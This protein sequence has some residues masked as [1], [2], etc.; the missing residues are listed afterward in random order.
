MTFHLQ[1]STRPCFDYHCAVLRTL[2]VLAR[3]GVG[4]PLQL[5]ESKQLSEDEEKKLQAQTPEERMRM[6]MLSGGGGG[7]GSAPWMMQL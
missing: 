3:V 5:E 4:R 7:G 2:C 6:Q 1:K